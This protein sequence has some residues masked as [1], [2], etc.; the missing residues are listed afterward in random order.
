[1]PLKIGEE[2]IL[3]IATVIGYGLIYNPKYNRIV[4]WTWMIVALFGLIC[5]SITFFV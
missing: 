2:V 1:M 3:F 4:A 5:A